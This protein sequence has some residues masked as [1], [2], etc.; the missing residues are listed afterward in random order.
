[1]IADER[2]V[3]AEWMPAVSVILESG[4]IAI[5][6]HTD[7]VADS[8]RGLLDGPP[9]RF[10]SSADSGLPWNVTVTSLDPA[11]E[12]TDFAAR[13]RLLIAGMALLVLMASAASYFVVRAITRE[14]AVARLQSDFVAA[15]SHEFRTPLT[16]LRQFTE[17]LQDSPALDDE[18]RRVA[19]A[20]QARA[21]HRLTRLVES[22][23]DFGRMEAGTHPYVFAPCDC[24][25]LVRAIVDDVREEAARSGHSIEVE[26]PQTLTCAFDEEALGRAFRNVLENAVKY[27][28]DASGVHV[29]VETRGD[30]VAISVTDRGIGIPAAERTA[31][32]TRFHRGAEARIRGI[33][34]TGIGLALV[35]EIVR[36]HK[37]RVEVISEVGQ[38]STFT[39]VL[40]L[41]QGAA[42]TSVRL[43]SQHLTWP[44]S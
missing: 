20:A 10:R 41:S 13:R 26:A 40:P 21:A 5:S 17:M 38:G 28:P 34:G 19:Y 2:F 43:G 30:T 44:E 36:A 27:S 9:Q 31:V 7:L 8:S 22:L 14:I 33:K 4:K 37:G 18:R 39:L 1:L 25:A 32:F 23:L 24:V 16:S 42:E 3:D 11:P 6:L 12:E 35:D 29:G 15:V